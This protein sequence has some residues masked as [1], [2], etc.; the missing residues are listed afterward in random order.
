MNFGGFGEFGED[1]VEEATR[2]GLGVNDHWQQMKGVMMET[3]QDICGMTKDPHRH[4]ETWW[5]N[6]EVAEAARE[7]K[8]KYGKWKKENTKEGRKEYKKSR[9]NANRVISSAKEK[10][11]K[12]CANDLNDSECQ[13]EIFEWQSRCRHGKAP[14][15][16]LDCCTPVTD[17]VGRQRLRSA[18]QQLMWSPDIGY[19]LLDAE[20]LLCTAPWSGTLYRT[21]SA[22]SRT[23]GLSD[24]V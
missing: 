6:E 15:Y 5:W 24:R 21:T 13:N 17:V 18:T 11:Q 20:H 16:L 14:Q 7:K 22:H 23:M 4:K 19:P 3:A 1:K 10:K 12:K 9:Q 8:I 2:K